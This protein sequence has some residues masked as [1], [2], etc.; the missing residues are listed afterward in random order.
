MV[1]SLPVIVNTGMPTNTGLVL[2]RSAVVSA[3]SPVS[4]STDSSV[5]FVSD[6]TALRAVW[7]V[8]HN[9]TRPDRIG[10]FSVTASGS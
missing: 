6:S 9:V 3:V 2:D 1:L 7:R 4:V 10:K 5:Y 8:G